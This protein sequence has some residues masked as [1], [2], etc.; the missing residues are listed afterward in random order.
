V[1]KPGWGW[2]GHQPGQYLRVGVIVDGIHYWRAYSL[3]SPPEADYISITPKTV[4]EGKVSPYLNEI[5]NPGTLVRLGGVQGDFTLPD[6]PPE[7]VL[8]ISAGSGI[9]PIM[10]MLR[11]LDAEG[12]VPDIVHLHSAGS[13]ERVIFGDEIEGAAGECQRASSSAVERSQRRCPPVERRAA[14]V[15]TLLGPRA[16][17]GAGGR[18]GGDAGGVGGSA[19]SSADPLK[20]TSTRTR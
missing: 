6:D 3:T 15:R 19:G 4:P 2:K 17:R 18:Q 11:G 13:R 20:V 12:S 9:T 7:K 1:I 8:M 5:A 14:P 16:R 10:S